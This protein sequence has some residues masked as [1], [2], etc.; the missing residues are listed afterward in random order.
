MSTKVA[1]VMSTT[2]KKETIDEAATEWRTHIEPFK[3]SGMERAYMF[4]DRQ[5]GRVPVDHN[6]ESGEVQIR[7]ATSGGQTAGRD[8][9]TRK[10]FEAPPTPSQ[11]EIVAIVE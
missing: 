6:L 3:G 8:A 7:N 10:Y 1:R 9:M 4:V 11:F 2:L 5:T